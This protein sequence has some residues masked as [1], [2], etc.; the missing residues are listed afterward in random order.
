MDT[1]AST[2]YLHLHEGS[3]AENEEELLV[4][5]SKARNE[6]TKCLTFL[7]H[8]CHM[9]VV[10]SPTCRLDPLLAR[11]LRLAHTLRYVVDPPSE[12]VAGR[13]A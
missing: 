1:A 9:I 10:V 13:R 8:A 6:R 2:V 7:L 3:M 5:V 11:Q 4:R 12:G